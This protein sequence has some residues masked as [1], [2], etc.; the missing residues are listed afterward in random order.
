MLDIE[1]NKN[2]LC[3]TVLCKVKVLVQYDLKAPEKNSRV[4]FSTTSPD[5][6]EKNKYDILKYYTSLTKNIVTGI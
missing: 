1:K 4:I 3:L 5:L 6:H 2:N